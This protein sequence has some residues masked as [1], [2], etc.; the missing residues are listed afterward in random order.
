MDYFFWRNEIICVSMAN[1]HTYKKETHTKKNKDRQKMSIHI[2]YCNATVEMYDGT[3]K[4]FTLEGSDREV[5]SYLFHLYP[6]FRCSIYQGQTVPRHLQS[7]LSVSIEVNEV[8]PIR[9]QKRNPDLERDAIEQNKQIINLNDE[10]IRSEWDIPIGHSQPINNSSSSQLSTKTV[11][12]PHNHKKI[13]Q[14]TRQFDPTKQLMKIN[15]KTKR[16]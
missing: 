2:S 7:K 13:Y 9:I 12:Q 16:Q 6:L 15:F 8:L 5:Y 4:K 1:I 11:V 3:K 14:V 10:K